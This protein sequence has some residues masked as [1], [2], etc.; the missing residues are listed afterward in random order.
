MIKVGFKAFLALVVALSFFVSHVIVGYSV[1]VSG[2]PTFAYTFPRFSGWIFYSTSSGSWTSFASGSAV[3]SFVSPYSSFSVSSLSLSRPESYIDFDLAF[4]YE[5]YSFKDP[6]TNRLQTYQFSS[7]SPVSVPVVVRFRSSVPSSVLLRP[8]V[9]FMSSYFDPTERVDLP[10]VDVSVL[11]VYDGTYYTYSFSLSYSFLSTASSS[12]IC[13][14]Q[15][16]FDG[17]SSMDISDFSLSFPSAVVLFRF[18]H[19]ILQR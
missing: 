10:M 5:D 12:R 2:T 1:N 18:W 17:I 3:S 4:L 6:V 7:F 19:S 15:F 8:S 13:G 9:H 14:I 11:P 16:H